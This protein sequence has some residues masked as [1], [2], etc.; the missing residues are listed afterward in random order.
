MDNIKEDIKVLYIE[1]SE[2]LH[3]DIKVRAATRNI[4]LKNYVLQAILSKIAEEKKY[5]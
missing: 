5:E 2:S 3:K 1:I 4:S